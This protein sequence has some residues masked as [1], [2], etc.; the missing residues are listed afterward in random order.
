MR[1]S[2]PAFLAQ[3]GKQLSDVSYF[4]FHPGG[5]KILDHLEDELKISRE[6]CRWSWDVLQNVGNMSS[7]SISFVIRSFLD[8]AEGKESVGKSVVVLGIGPGLTVQ[9]VLCEL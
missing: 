7:T 1:G 3:H 9:Y 2:L 4:L 8:S 6:Q 5:A